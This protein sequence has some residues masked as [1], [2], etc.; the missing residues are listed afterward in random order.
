MNLNE[1][2]EEID[3]IDNQLVKL[4]C[5][6]M[7]CSLKVAEVK[8]KEALP[9]LNSEREQ[10]ILDK[11]QKSGGE[12]GNYL[13][14]IY[15]SIMESSRDFQNDVLES[16]NKI[17]QD[18]KAARINSA[19][20][21]QPRNVLCQGVEGAFS[22]QAAINYYPDSNINF[23]T[24]FEDVFK[25]VDTGDAE[26][27]IVPVEN[28]SAGSVLD[29]YDLILKY[30]HYIIGAVDMKIEQNLL[31]LKGAKLS[32][33]KTVYSQPHAL[34]QCDDFIKENQLVAEKYINT[35]AAAKMVSQKGDT[36]CAA[37]GSKQAAELYG[38]EIIKPSIQTKQNNITRF[39]VVSK[40]LIIQNDSDK[41]SL[42]FTLPHIKGSLSNT[43]SR[44]TRHGFNLTKIE[45]RPTGESFEYQFYLDFTGDTSDPNTLKLLA[46]L[47][48]EMPQ[49]TFLGNYK[50]I[51]I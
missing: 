32:D 49:F 43:L 38:L 5:R 18:I 45:S 14:T 12:Y 4:L 10:Q 6:R 47:F 9:V 24:S 11:I 31:G 39:I 1:I 15:Q 41:I 29:V 30:R 48:D 8:R 51:K 13:Y 40:K 50:E 3:A 27:G 17:V 28:S 21:T 34:L 2:R 23:C 42:V 46:S 33:I 26:V 20:Y 22:H 35:A 37:I 16:E 36:S 19:N 7:D 25:A 44:F